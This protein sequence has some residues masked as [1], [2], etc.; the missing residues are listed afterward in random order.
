MP[1]LKQRLAAGESVVVCAVGRVL[2]HNFIQ[3]IGVAG[4]FDGLWIDMEHVGITNEQLEITTL[5]AR[6]HGLDTFC[7]IPPTDY[8][9]V[10]RCYEA[11]A[12]GVMAAQ[13][14]SAAQ[15][16]EFVRWAKF[17]PR[18]NRGLNTG[19]WDARFT[20]IPA[21]EFCRKAND[22]HMVAIQIETLQSL[23]EVDAIAAIDGVDMLFVGPADLSQALGVTGEFF[24]EK[25]L[26]AI[27]RVAAACVK[28]GKPWGAVS[29]SP[30]HAEMLVS[31]GCR[32][33]SPTNDTRIVLAGI[34]AVKQD[35]A[36]YFK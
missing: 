16:E 11:G 29:F 35:F 3:L 21:A 23:E 32:L 13:I 12:G 25:C 36:K 28:H 8:A 34:H 6:A 20:T 15:A 18:G 7:R 22:E 9:T 4:G 19:G 10:T 31:K 24:H 14:F 17:A 27:D 5:A 26:A 30:Q 2:Q 1:T 33:L